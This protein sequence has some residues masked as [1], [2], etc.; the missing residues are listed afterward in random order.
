[1]PHP[2][3]LGDCTTSPI[4]RV[5]LSIHL[6]HL[7]CLAAA[8]AAAVT[9]CTLHSTAQQSGAAA[10]ATS[11]AAQ[12]EIYQRETEEEETQPLAQQIIVIAVLQGERGTAV[13][14]QYCST[15]DCRQVDNE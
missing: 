1:M 2:I 4:N 9:F 3:I 14:T 8:A 12:G 15:A 6:C 5:V 11:A 7:G 13:C 10:C